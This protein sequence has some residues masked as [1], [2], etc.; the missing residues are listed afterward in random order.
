MQG[1]VVRT[2]DMSAYPKVPQCIAMLVQDRY[3]AHIGSM[4]TY[5]RSKATSLGS[6]LVIYVLVVVTE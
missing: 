4:W 1:D 6:L 5:S 2:S 3:N